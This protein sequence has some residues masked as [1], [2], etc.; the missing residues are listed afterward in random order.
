MLLM[1]SI[2]ALQVRVEVGASEEVASTDKAVQRV[3][4]QNLAYQAAER[5][6]NRWL[7]DWLARAP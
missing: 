3:Y 1:M 4:R 2:A 7:I 5:D 6:R